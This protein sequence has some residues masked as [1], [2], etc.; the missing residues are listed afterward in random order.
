MIA[1]TAKKRQYI[2]CIFFKK[3]VV[4][5]W[6]FL[7]KLIMKETRQLRGIKVEDFLGNKNK[8]EKIILLIRRTSTIHEDKIKGF[9]SSDVIGYW[10]SLLLRSFISGYRGP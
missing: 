6:L 5:E 1:K 3:E 8:V 4:F 9:F 2:E 10:V 7:N